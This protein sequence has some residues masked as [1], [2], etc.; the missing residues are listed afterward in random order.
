MFIPPLPFIYIIF[1]RLDPPPNILDDF[2]LRKQGY[3]IKVPSQRFEVYMF[4]P[5]VTCP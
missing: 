5:Q 1:P 2:I 3:D 4:F